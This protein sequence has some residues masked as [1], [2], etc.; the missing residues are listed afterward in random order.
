MG[1]ALWKEGDLC[2]A[3]GTHE[4]RPMGVAIIASNGQFRARDFRARGKVPKRDR[5]LFRG[6]FASMEAMNAYLSGGER[7]RGKRTG[8]QAMEIL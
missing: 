1:F 4:Y 3:L 6:F 7:R 5:R 2:W 8:A